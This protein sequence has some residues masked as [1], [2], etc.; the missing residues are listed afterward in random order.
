MTKAITI[1]LVLL[2]LLLVV[3]LGCAW[4]SGPVTLSRVLLWACAHY[5]MVTGAGVLWLLCRRRPVV[6]KRWTV[7]TADTSEADY[8]HVDD[9]W[10][11][12]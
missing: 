2:A 10:G 5:L 3:A 9:D 4:L 7:D 11:A 1:G 12:I 8:W 6:A